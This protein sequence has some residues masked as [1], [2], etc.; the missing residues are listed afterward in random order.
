MRHRNIAEQAQ[1]LAG[2]VVLRTWCECDQLIITAARTLENA[3]RMAA[4]VL[5]QHAGFARGGNR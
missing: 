3:Q 5:R 1:A 4:R 2:G